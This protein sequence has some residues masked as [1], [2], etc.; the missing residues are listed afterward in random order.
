MVA[1]AVVLV[2]PIRVR[3]MSI[4]AM[5]EDSSN[6]FRFNVYAAVF[7][8]IKAYPITGIG[9]GNEAFNS[10]YPLFQSP[11]YTAL[12]AYSIYF[13]TLVEGGIIGGLAFLWMLLLNF[14]QGLGQLGRLRRAMTIDGL[15]LIAALGGAAGLLVQG[16]FDTVWYRPQLSTLWWMLLAIVASFY[17]DTRQKYKALPSVEMEA[18][19]GDYD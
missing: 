11:R 15:W 17:A 8:M 4:F 7:K 16:L 1:A 10:I 6:N 3:V 12:S 19:T 9:P 13:E 14:L 5:R 2:P 18:A